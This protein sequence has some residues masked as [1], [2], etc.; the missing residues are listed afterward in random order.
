MTILNSK[1]DIVNR[2]HPIAPSALVQVFDVKNPGTI[3]ANGTMQPGVIEPGHIV[4]YDSTGKAD[5]A[6]SPD[7]SA[8]EPVLLWVAVDGDTDFSGRF[9][10]R[11]T[12]M[13][14]GITVKTDKY[15]AGTYTPGAPLKVVSGEFSPT[16]GAGDTAQR[17]GYVGPAGLDAVNGVLEVIIPQSGGAQK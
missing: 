15:A 10:R 6:S 17:Y 3:D 12:A 5:L 9:V 1:F 4:A 13:A 14:G 2:E 16:T 8:A 7:L 11:V